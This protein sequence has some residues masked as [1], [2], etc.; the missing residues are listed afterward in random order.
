MTNFSSSG[1]EALILG[2]VCLAAKGFGTATKKAR[3][4]VAIETYNFVSMKSSSSK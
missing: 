1:D 2:V 4:K 3:D